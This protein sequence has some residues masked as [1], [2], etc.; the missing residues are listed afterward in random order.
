MNEGE[1][2]SQRELRFLEAIMDLLLQHA[3]YGPYDN[4]NGTAPIYDMGL[5]ANENAIAILKEY[6]LCENGKV[7]FRRLEVLMEEANER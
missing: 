1:K 2:L 4:K 6:N 7:Y 5:S 3:D